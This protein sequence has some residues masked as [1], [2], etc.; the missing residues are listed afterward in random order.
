LEVGFWNSRKGHRM[1]I[2]PGLTDGD[3]RSKRSDVRVIRC[4]REEGRGKKEENIDGRRKK[5]PT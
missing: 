2:R 5:N 1:K 4:K 3:V